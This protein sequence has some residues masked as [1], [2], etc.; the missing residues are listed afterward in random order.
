MYPIATA[1]GN[2]S[3]AIYFNNIPQNFT[4]LQIRILGRSGTSGTSGNLYH[5][6]NAGGYTYSN[7]QLYGN[8]SSIGSSS[9]TGLPYV[10]FG[11]AFPAASSTANI[12]GA[13]II[14]WFDYTNTNKYKVCRVTGGNDQNGSG[15]VQI[16]S[17]LIQ[18]TGAMT[19]F[20][21]DTEGSFTTATTVQL[22]GIS[23]SSVTGA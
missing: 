2:G 20:F 9:N 14:D 21:L 23:T 4:H 18:T 12:M 8:G 11:S 3:G 15:V 6:I 13:F 5:N 10:F 19:S 1:Q 7:H 17:G 16:S 22:Y